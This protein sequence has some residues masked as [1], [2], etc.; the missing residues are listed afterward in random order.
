MTD[1]ELVVLRRRYEAACQAVAVLFANADDHGELRGLSPV[2]LTAIG[3]YRE[4]AAAYLP[5]PLP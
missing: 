2:L 4:A 5:D 1:R 3:N